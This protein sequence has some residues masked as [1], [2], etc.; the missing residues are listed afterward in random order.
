MSRQFEPIVHV[1]SKVRDFLNLIT[2]VD[3]LDPSLESPRFTLVLNR[4][5]DLLA[6]FN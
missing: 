2:K 4:D 3:E 1:L 6:A 5:L